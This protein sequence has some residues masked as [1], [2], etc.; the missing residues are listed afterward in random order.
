MDVKS[1]LRDHIQDLVLSALDMVNKNPTYR[2]VIAGGRAVEHYM[3]PELQERLV[4]TMEYRRSFDYDLLLYPTDDRS[5]EHPYVWKDDVTKSPPVVPP[6]VDDLAKEIRRFYND[7][8]LREV[9]R[10]ALLSALSTGGHKVDVNFDE[11]FVGEIRHGRVWQFR[12]RYTTDGEPKTT[13]FVNISLRLRTHQV[14]KSDQKIPEYT[15]DAKLKFTDPLSVSGVQRVEK[16]LYYLH[17][18]FDSSVGTISTR[19][20][21][22]THEHVFVLRPECLFMDQMDWLGTVENC[23]EILGGRTNYRRLVQSLGDILGL[24]DQ[25]AQFLSAT[26]SLSPKEVA[27][28]CENDYNKSQFKM[29]LIRCIV[30][31]FVCMHLETSRVK[32]FDPYH[33]FKKTVTKAVLPPIATPVE[34]ATPPK[35]V[36]PPVAHVH[37]PNKHF[38]PPGHY[39]KKGKPTKPTLLPAHMGADLKEEE[40]VPEVR[41]LQSMQDNLNRFTTNYNY[42]LDCLS[43]AV[44][45]HSRARHDS[46][47]IRNWARKF[48]ASLDNWDSRK[49]QFV[50]D[51]EKLREEW[52]NG[53]KYKMQCTFALDVELYNKLNEMETL[54][55]KLKTPVYH[56]KGLTIINEA[57]DIVAK[58]REA[59][60]KFQLR[61]MQLNQLIEHTNS[62]ITDLQNTIN[63]KENTLVGLGKW[64]FSGVAAAG[65]AATDAAGAA[66][67]IAAAV[68]A[69]PVAV[70]SAMMGG[71]GFGGPAGGKSR[72]PHRNERRVMYHPPNRASRVRQSEGW[73]GGGGAGGDGDTLTVAQLSTLF[74]LRSIANL[75]RPDERP[76]DRPYVTMQSNPT[77][78]YYILYEHLVR[79]SMVTY[80]GTTEC[81]DVVQPV[82]RQP[83]ERNK[84]VTAHREIDTFNARMLQVYNQWLEKNIRAGRFEYSTNGMIMYSQFPSDRQYLPETVVTMWQS[85][86]T[87]CGFMTRDDCSEQLIQV[88]TAVANTITTTNPGDVVATLGTYF[89]YLSPNIREVITTMMYCSVMYEPLDA[90]NGL[91]AYSYNPPM[92]VVSKFHGGCHLGIVDSLDDGTE[93]YTMKIVSTSMQNKIPS[94]IMELPGVKHTLKRGRTLYIYQLPP[95]GF[96]PIFRMAGSAI[97]LQGEQEVML[98]PFTKCRLLGKSNRHVGIF[99]QHGDSSRPNL[100]ET[101]SQ[102]HPMRVVEVQVIEPWWTYSPA[103]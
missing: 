81:S 90:G 80:M 24:N 71:W 102:Y 85:D 78:R 58:T 64:L 7:A 87:V 19:T 96:I 65:T 66:V 30:I 21:N 83:S 73:V 41:D 94:A 20:V 43:E 74:D 55:H 27:H 54:S 60:T 42:C 76:Q 39:I 15:D 47:G 1:R 14:I 28:H 44:D 9:R 48:L 91:Y 52:Q 2:F 57:L 84:A 23:A 4:D 31:G 98:P 72:N 37:K 46:M 82:T 77:H 38:D 11:C 53:E 51:F 103:S 69:L 33:H 40:E 34:P 88:S 68:A 62:E 59:R 8:P 18:G 86:P 70:V 25:V 12:F 92:T 49:E 26:D 101:P 50:I 16:R 95:K 99:N 35:Q 75:V 5:T 63:R 36:Q 13:A 89:P 32:V 45:L 22:T 10:L 3:L 56:E 29:R 79:N 6:A 97:D 100:P 93:F 61:Y 67:V 17:V